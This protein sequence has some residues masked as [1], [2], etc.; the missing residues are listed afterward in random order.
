MIAE[1]FRVRED[2]EVKLV[3][4]IEEKAVQVKADIFKEGEQSNEIVA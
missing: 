1:E 2:Q 4:Q 3:R